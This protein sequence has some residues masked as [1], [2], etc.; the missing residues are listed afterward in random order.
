MPETAAALGTWEESQVSDN[1]LVAPSLPRAEKTQTL[2][3][4]T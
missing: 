1:N 3:G 4:D 2:P